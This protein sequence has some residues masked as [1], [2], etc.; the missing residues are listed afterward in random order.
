MS[1]KKSTCVNYCDGRNARHTLC[2]VS[3]RTEKA[4][5]L[6]CCLTFK[7]E[8]EEILA[9]ICSLK[10]SMASD[11][12]VSLN[13]SEATCLLMKELMGAFDASVF[14]KY[15]PDIN[16]W[17]VWYYIFLNPHPCPL[18]DIPCD[19]LLRRKI[20]A[21][22][23]CQ[24]SGHAEL[25]LFALCGPNT[26]GYIVPDTPNCNGGGVSTGNVTYLQALGE[27][28]KLLSLALEAN[29]MVCNCSC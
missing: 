26:T 12:N 23:G 15:I 13:P 29:N 17:P 25:S 8:I 11:V 27:L 3:D 10:V 19:D 18:K 24:P 20:V 5:A 9:I 1:P 22:D 6:L 2:P 28:E 16:G 4:R 7:Q 21:V 14:I